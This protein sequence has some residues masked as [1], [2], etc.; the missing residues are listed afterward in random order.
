MVRE[1]LL[2]EFFKLGGN[3]GNKEKIEK[4]EKK[5]LKYLAKEKDRFLSNIL[6]IL[7]LYEKGIKADF[8]ECYEIALPVVEM[9]ED[10]PISKWEIWDIRIARII[11][12][13]TSTFERAEKLSRKTLSALQKYGKFPVGFIVHV[14]MLT[15]LTKADFFE[16]DINTEFE[17]SKKIKE[18]FEEHLEIALAILQEKEKEGEETKTYELLILIRASLYYRDYNTVDIHLKALKDLGEKEI[19]NA[20][21]EAISLYAP[22]AGSTISDGMFNIMCG[23]AVKRVQDEFGLTLEEFGI[24][25]GGY[26]DSHMGN[27]ISGNRN[28][29]AAQLFRISKKFNISM[30]ELFGEP[31]KD[32]NCY[33][34]ERAKIERLIALA[35]GL[36]DASMELLCSAAIQLHKI[37]FDRKKNKK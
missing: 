12:V 23:A 9:L 27:L 6:I 20:T 19:Y 31:K 7:K 13:F 8:K 30:D 35:E 5:V 28:V 11:L 16:V 22:H 26:S 18:Y 3:Y 2:E 4:L 36:D 1:E 15:R 33:N 34:K 32:E 21:K 24:I 29:Y 25:L 14:S 10:M 17:R 37:G